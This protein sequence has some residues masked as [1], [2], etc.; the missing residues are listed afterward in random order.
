MPDYIPNVRLR[1]W[2]NE[3][4]LSRAEMADQ[5]NATAIG[6]A[7]QLACDEERVRRWEAGEVRWPRT[8]NRLAL[9]QLTGLELEALGFSQSK[10]AGSGLIEARCDPRRR[11][12]APRPICTGPWNLPSNSRPPTSEPARWRHE[13]F[14]TAR[15]ALMSRRPDLLD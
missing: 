2:R 6:V 14:V 8:P 13:R 11:P 1:A 4:R 12:C 7:E 15:R 5:I 9:T 3:R 10:Q